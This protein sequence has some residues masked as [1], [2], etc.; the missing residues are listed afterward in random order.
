MSSKFEKAQQKA[1]KNL[2]KYQEQI[3]KKN[4]KVIENALAKVFKLNKKK[5]SEIDVKERGL[6][7]AVIHKETLHFHQ[8]VKDLFDAFK[9][10]QDQCPALE[11]HLSHKDP[12]TVVMKVDWNAFMSSKPAVAPRQGLIGA[13]PIAEKL[14]K[15]EDA[16]ANKINN[17]IKNLFENPTLSQLGS[18]M[19]WQKV[20]LK[21]NTFNLPGPSQ[22]FRDLVLECQ[23]KYPYLELY[24]LTGNTVILRVYWALYN[25]YLEQ[26]AGPI[27]GQ[28]Q[29][30]PAPMQYQIPQLMMMQ[31]QHM[32]Q[33]QYGQPMQQHAYFQAPPAPPRQPAP[34]AQHEEWQPMPDQWP[35]EARAPVVSTYKSKKPKKVGKKGSPQAK[36]AEVIDRV[37]SQ[38]PPAYAGPQ[39][40]GTPHQQAM[41]YPVQQGMYPV[42]QHGY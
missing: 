26:G 36:M 31:Q 21:K 32:M 20:I 38:W 19:S 23:E 37:A 39:L 33:Q 15:L 18:F 42:M 8:T 5:R 17:A 9:T 12:N 1:E 2:G 14:Q 27:A 24:R 34:P 16:N 13:N 29:Q 22:H 35:A 40:S 11:I 7:K 25:H 28:A 30:Q 41:Y 6:F 3:K 10:Y 4:R